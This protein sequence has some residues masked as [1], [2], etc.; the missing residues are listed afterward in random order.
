MATS[1]IIFYLVFCG[2][3]ILGQFQRIELPPLPAFYLLDVLM[4]S[5]GGWL[6]VSQRQ[7]VVMLLRRLGKSWAWAEKIL[8]LWLA[9]GWLV[10]IISGD[11]SG[12]AFFY[13]SRFAVYSLTLW[14][15]FSLQVLPSTW[16]RVG[17]IVAGLY[18][19]LWGFGQYLLLPDM[20]F[21]SISGWDDHYFRLVGTQLDPNFMGLIFVLLFLW[22]WQWPWQGR[23]QKLLGVLLEIL[24]VGGIALT[25]S[26]STL[27]SFGVLM[28]F[29]AG[30]KWKN[31]WPMLLVVI[32]LFLAQK[33]T[34]EG[35]DLTRTA[36]IEARVVS[37]ERSLLEL[38]PYQWVIGRGLFNTSKSSYV[39]EDYLR[40][41]HAGLPDNLW[42]LVVQS[43][44]I[45]G[46]GLVLLVAS[47]WVRCCIKTNPDGAGA[48][49][50]VL[51]HAM[52]NN[53]LFQP[54]IFLLLG[55]TLISKVDR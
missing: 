42:L 23:G 31:Y 3:I 4:L 6:V 20:R 39:S 46:L 54:F 35:V 27:I 5:W 14:L 25:F 47:R 49:L 18:S 15:I 19:L 22:L 21:L 44:G 43:G 17:L 12:Q 55:M 8:I 11:F 50:A 2:L 7:K 32:I 48:I 37:S 33:P 36:S 1:T 30:K 41:D 34:Y 38:Q 24:V 16:L 13:L 45:V 53:S 10:A 28:I 29:L 52:F 51:V 40:A 26:R 9:L